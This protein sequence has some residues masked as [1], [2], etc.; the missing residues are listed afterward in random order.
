MHSFGGVDESV[1]GCECHWS[2]NLKKIPKVWL[3]S[4]NFWKALERLF[5]NQPI[6][7][8]KKLCN[9]KQFTITNN[10]EDDQ[11]TLLHMGMNPL[12]QFKF[13]CQWETR[14]TGKII[15]MNRDEF[16]SVLSYFSKVAEENPYVQIKRGVGL[17]R[18]VPTDNCVV[19]EQ[20]KQV[21][22]VR[23]G[24]TVISLDE[25]AMHQLASLKPVIKAYMKETVM[26]AFTY[27]RD[28]MEILYNYC[29]RKVQLE[30]SNYSNMVKFFRTTIE[31]DCNCVQN[32]DFLLEMSLNVFDWAYVCA[33]IFF[34]LL[35][36]NE[37]AR[38]DT[39]CDP[40]FKMFENDGEKQRALSKQVNLI[41]RRA[42]KSGLYMVGCY[43]GM[44]QCAFCYKYVHLDDCVRN[45][46]VETHS[47]TSP[48]C[49]FLMKPSST[50]N[51]PLNG[52]NQS[53]R[54]KNHLSV[55]FVV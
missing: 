30:V 17:I 53:L 25:R 7:T 5:E 22:D 50:N 6:N 55:K 45:D 19:K 51:I 8:P 48:R 44:M 9:L 12:N 31:M 29:I 47:K 28:L 52:T 35:M 2:K 10:D 32:K 39:F 11:V 36:I 42:A 46:I 14:P 4:S 16:D 54:F 26:K 34:R 20:E 38:L 1:G 43:S 37:S 15:H 23:V 27:E 40:Q 49:P 24:N 21:Y 3:N 13:E 41:K 18:H 33:P